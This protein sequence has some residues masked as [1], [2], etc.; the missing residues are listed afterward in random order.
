MDKLGNHPEAI[1]LLEK[2]L[3]YLKPSPSLHLIAGVLLY[4][5]EEMNRALKHFRAVVE[6]VKQD[7]RGYYNMAMVYKKQGMPEFA[8]KYF[9]KADM[10]RKKTDAPS[11]KSS[12]KKQKKGGKSE[13]SSGRTRV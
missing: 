8:Q 3:E 4:K 12:G 10:L 6:L 7:W 1:D 5:A 9:A 11:V 2:A 13:L